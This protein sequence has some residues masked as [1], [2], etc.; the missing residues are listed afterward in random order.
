MNNSSFIN[1]SFNIY[2]IN[3]DNNNI[4]TDKN[5]FINTNNNGLSLLNCKVFIKCQ[6]ATKFTRALHGYISRQAIYQKKINKY[7]T[8][9]KQALKEYNKYKEMLSKSLHI[10]N[11]IKDKLKEF[12]NKSNK[13]INRIIK[14]H[15]AIFRLEQKSR[16][17]D[18]IDLSVKN[19]FVY[20]YIYAKGINTYFYKGR[21]KTIN[22]NKKIFIVEFKLLFQSYRYVQF[23]FSNLC[24]INDTYISPINQ[25]L[26]AALFIDPIS[27]TNCNI[28]N[29]PE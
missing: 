17:N 6:D 1:P 20:F 27:K 24:V 10:N 13:N 29:I 21:I 16:L 2:D 11:K 25:V 19:I 8:I 7:L 15:S 5:V 14:Y 28:I 9:V 4:I 18:D 22:I 3:I 23:K 12:Y 26:T